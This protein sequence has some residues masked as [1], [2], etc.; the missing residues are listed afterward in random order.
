MEHSE[1][2][3]ITLICICLEGIFILSCKINSKPLNTHGAETDTVKIGT[4]T[5]T[6]KAGTDQTI[7]LSQT[8][9]VMLDG[10][11]YS[12]GTYKWTD[13]SANIGYPMLM[14]LGVEGQPTN[15]ATLTSPTSKTTTVTGYL[16]VYGIIR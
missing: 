13:I 15:T 4:G 9:K 11:A 12:G 2:S 5:D 8:S 7:Y 10:S 6:V 1:A 14:N 3:L 16:K